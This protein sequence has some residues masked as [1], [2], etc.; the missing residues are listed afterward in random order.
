MVLHT[1]SDPGPVSPPAQGQLTSEPV[2]FTCK[3]E[4]SAAAPGLAGCRG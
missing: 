4:V 1:E 3:V 2:F